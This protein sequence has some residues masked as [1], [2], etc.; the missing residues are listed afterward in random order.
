MRSL[1][2]VAI[3]MC[4]GVAQAQWEMQASGTKASLRGIDALGDGVVWA[5]GTE[6]TVLRT[7]DGGEHWQRCTVPGGAE[8]L[9]FRGVQAFDATTA[10]VMASGTGE[11][12]RLYKTTDGCATWTQVF[13]NPDKDGFF[14]EMQF[15]DRSTGVL[16]GDPVQGHFVLFK[17]TDGGA[18]WL[19]QKGDGL[20]ADPKRQ[21]AF[22]ASNESLMLHRSGKTVS[23]AFVTGGTAGAML[24]RCRETKPGKLACSNTALRLGTPAESA[25]AFAAAQHA[26][27]AVVVGGDYKEPEGTDAALFFDGVRWNP[28]LR[29][30]HGYRSAV[31]YDAVQQVWI[32]VGPNGTDLSLDEGRTWKAL[33]PGPQDG[34]E[35]DTGWNALSLPF[36]VGSKGKI[37]VLRST[38]VTEA[39]QQS[40][41]EENGPGAQ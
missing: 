22:A 3:A 35:E 23:A 39:K 6:G 36:V 26:G 21:G 4:C 2:M 16:L 18:H 19:R 27:G 28:A 40:A 10:L 25:G 12:S 20:A 41:A 30:P 14:D 13:A 24:Y 38:A 11:L 8:A 31:A 7:V 5:S 33:R 15:L 9:D 1:W 29:E 32:T 37:G 17:T 34:S